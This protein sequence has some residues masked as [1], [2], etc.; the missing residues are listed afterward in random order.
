A[1]DPEQA[2]QFNRGQQVYLIPTTNKK[3]KPSWDI[4][5]LDAPAAV[6]TT[7]SQQFTDPAPL[8]PQQKQAIAEYISG[9]ADLLAY[10]WKVVEEK[11]AGKAEESHRCAVSSLYIAASR[12][13]NL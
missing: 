10:C 5:L 12:K 3:G 13:F 8:T 7:A 6:P 9:Q 4:E 11:L 1:M 2:T